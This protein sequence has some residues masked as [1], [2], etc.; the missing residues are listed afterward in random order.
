MLGIRRL[1]YQGSVNSVKVNLVGFL[2]CL[3]GSIR[4]YCFGVMPYSSGVFELFSKSVFST[5]LQGML[6]LVVEN[7]ECPILYLAMKYL[8]R[9]Q[10]HS[11]TWLFLVCILII[12]H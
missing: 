10:K 8:P 12:Y 6:L 3:D 11:I 7:K 1:V 5:K 9:K 4:K 2:T